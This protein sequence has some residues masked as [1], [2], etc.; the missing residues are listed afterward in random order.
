M[1]KVLSSGLILLLMLSACSRSDR[2]SN[3]FFSEWQTPLGAPP[4][5]RIKSEHFL[6]AFREAM[7]RHKAEIRAI[8]VNP[9]VPTFANTI[10]ALDYSGELLEKVTN[11][12]YSLNSANTSDSMQALARDIAPILSSH[13]DDISLNDTLFQRIKTVYLQKDQ[14]QLTT[15][16]ATLLELSLIHI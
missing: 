6:P 10:E 11:I 7:W 2:E 5:D 15:E 13:Y 16:P 12:F 8:I 14:L 4:F 1:K 3:P 9:D